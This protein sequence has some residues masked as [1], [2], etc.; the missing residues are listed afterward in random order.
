MPLL[1]I[2]ALSARLIKRSL[3]HLGLTAY[4][5]KRRRP[6]II[7]TFHLVPSQE[8]ELFENTV[9]FLRAHF[10]LVSLSELVARSQ[11]DGSTSDTGCIALTFDDGLKHHADIVYPVLKRLGVPGTFYVC[12]ELVGRSGSIWT[13]ELHAR[14]KRLSQADRLRFFTEAGVSNDI[15]RLIDWMKT[16]PVYR[17]EEMESAI[18]VLTP[19]FEFTPPERAQFELMTWEQLRGLDPDL[20]TIGSHTATHVDLP[21]ADA[22]R[23]D[24]ELRHGRDLLQSTLGRPVEHFAYPNGNYSRDVLPSVRM[25]YR[26]A[27]TTRPG[28]VKAGDD[29]YLLNRLHAEFDLARLSW[30]LAANAY[31][32]L[33]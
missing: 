24:R 23:V 18:R 14:L 11:V 25:Y 7:L 21:Q 5:A 22:D 3:Y 29:P 28:I 27:V 2:R 4:Y 26:S 8:R 13:W 15:Q 19:A 9:R 30:N 20:I 17:R 12:A 10:R 31:R 32:D 33:R 1:P 16:I 6:N